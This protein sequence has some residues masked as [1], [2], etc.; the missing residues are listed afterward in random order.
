MIDLCK[1]QKD[2]ECEPSEDMMQNFDDITQGRLYFCSFVYDPK[3]K[4]MLC[5]LNEDILFDTTRLDTMREVEAEI[6][7]AEQYCYYHGNVLGNCQASET[8][9][10][11]TRLE[12]SWSAFPQ[13]HLCMGGDGLK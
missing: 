6:E 10:C 11:T 2:V 3:T 12:N 5:A 7:K 9:G 13:P 1:G 4:N 8:D